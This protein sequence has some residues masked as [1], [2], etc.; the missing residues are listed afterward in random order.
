M[1]KKIA[2][3]LLSAALILQT[4]GIPPASALRVGDGHQSV[5]QE[6]N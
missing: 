6:G 1:K 2:S 4:G 5:A 3:A